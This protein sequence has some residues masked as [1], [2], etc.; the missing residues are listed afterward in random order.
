[1]IIALDDE[2]VPHHGGH[3]GRHSGGSEAPSDFVGQWEA[4]NCYLLNLEFIGPFSQCLPWL[5]GPDDNR[6]AAI[7]I[8]DNRGQWGA[9]GS[10][11]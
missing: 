8:Q 2:D 5:P 4:V 1:M 11:I 7:P 10:S 3:H 6:P 9:S